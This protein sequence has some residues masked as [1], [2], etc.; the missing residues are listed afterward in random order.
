M[1]RR[2][3]KLMFLDWGKAMTQTAIRKTRLPRERGLLV[4]ESRKEFLRLRKAFHDEIHPCGAVERHYVDWIAMLAWEISRLVRIKADLVNCACFDALKNLLKQA[5]S[6]EGF[7]YHYQ[8]DKAAEDLAARWFVDEEVKAEA[9]TLLRKFGL[10]EVSIEAEAYRLRA[11]EIE[12]VDR[13]ITSKERCLENALRFI[14]KLRKN[15]GERLRQSSTELL[16]VEAPPI[17]V[18]AVK[19]AN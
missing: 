2:V 18:A 1:L 16:E 15:L 11:V 5:V 6:S 8:R 3:W 7:D 4:T 10:D 17:V 12:S 14:G 9:A 13:L 19:K